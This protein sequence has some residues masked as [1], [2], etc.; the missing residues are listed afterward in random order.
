MTCAGQ[1]RKKNF[2]LRP[3]SNTPVKL[4]INDFDQIIPRR[5]IRLRL[6]GKDLPVFL[7]H[8]MRPDPF[9]EKTKPEA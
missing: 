7:K 6:M 1:H 8:D 2:Y 9:P 5:I 3:D 4:W